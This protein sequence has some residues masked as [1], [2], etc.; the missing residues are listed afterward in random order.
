MSIKCVK[1]DRRANHY[2]SLL[3]RPIGGPDDRLHT[4][5][6]YPPAQTV[7]HYSTNRD[8]RRTTY[9]QLAASLAATSNV[10]W[11]DVKCR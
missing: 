11:E 8:R 10:D 5:M 1:Q 9:Q 4:E 3:S 7:T 6:V 2:T